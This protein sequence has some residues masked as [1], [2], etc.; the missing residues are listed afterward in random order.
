MAVAAGWRRSRWA[1][2]PAAPRAPAALNGLVGCKPSTGLIS[3]AGS[4]PLSDTLD[5]LGPIAR[6]V[7]DARALAVLL[8]GPDVDDAATLALPRA[9]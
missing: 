6:N 3:R 9:A 4:L 5:V 1:A 8:S 7:A 2:I